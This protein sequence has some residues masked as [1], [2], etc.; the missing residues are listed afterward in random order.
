MKNNI[1]WNSDEDRT[2]LRKI[3]HAFSTMNINNKSVQIKPIKSLKKWSAK[4]DLKLSNNN[5][6]SNIEKILLNRR[7]RKVPSYKDINEKLISN[8]FRF[9]FGISDYK[10]KFMTYPSPG[11]LYSI[12]IFVTID[13]KLF[14]GWIYRYNPY[15]HTLEKYLSITN[16]E[17]VEFNKTIINYQSIKFPIK[18]YFATDYQLVEEKYGTMTY[19]L[20]NQEVGHMAQNASLYAEYLKLN[21]CVIGGY[22]ENIFQKYI[23]QYD[24]LSVMVVG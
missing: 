3:T 22:Y 23:P 10:N 9:S 7:S 8:F 6:Y 11:A 12:T 19:R 14:Q 20:I 24:L 17:L 2:S 21:S 18:L 16:E 5:A 15:K 13:T 1:L 4:K